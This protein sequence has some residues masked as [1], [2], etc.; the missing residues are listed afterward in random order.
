MRARLSDRTTHADESL[1]KLSLLDRLVGLAGVALGVLTFV[2]PQPEAIVAAIGALLVV[3]YILWRS[4]DATSRA[5]EIAS[6]RSPDADSETTVESETSPSVRPEFRRVGDADEQLRTIVKLLLG[7]AVLA[8]GLATYQLLNTGFD[9]GVVWLYGV[10]VL[11]LHPVRVYLVA[12]RTVRYMLRPYR[13][14]PHAEAVGGTP[15][16]W[17]HQ[18]LLLLEVVVATEAVIAVARPRLFGAPSVR[19][20]PLSKAR[21]SSPGRGSLTI[22]V[23]NETIE[24][25]RAESQQVTDVVLICGGPE[26]THS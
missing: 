22:E 8:G 21:V 1:V 14:Q 10:A 11:L 4:E 23:E 6:V 9:G 18:A 2:L 25:V 3:A 12:L 5:P 20:F 7:F 15:G 26:P 17:W 24:I 19:T 16:P 13:D